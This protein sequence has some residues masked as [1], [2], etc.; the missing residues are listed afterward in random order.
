MQCM[1]FTFVV[2]MHWPVHACMSCCPSCSS[3]STLRATP[4]L[5]IAFVS[6]RCVCIDNVGRINQH[7]DAESGMCSLTYIQ[8]RRL[9]LAHFVSCTFACSTSSTYRCPPRVSVR[10]ATC[11]GRTRVT[12]SRACTSRTLLQRRCVS[13]IFVWLTLHEETRVSIIDDHTHV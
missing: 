8:V 11:A 12:L 10:A 6:P 13:S 3:F 9:R 4:N 2:S 1:A 5:P 7:R